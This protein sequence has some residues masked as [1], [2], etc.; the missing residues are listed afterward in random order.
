MCLIVAK[1]IGAA[2]PL[3]NHLRNGFMKNT[4]GSGV[5]FWKKDS[6]IIHIKKDFKTFPEF[7]Q[8]FTENVTVDD[9]CIVHFRLGTH[10]LSDIGNRH[11][12]P[13]TNDPE[14]LRTP[15]LDC[16]LATAHNGVLTQY[17]RADDKK[18]SDTQR[19]IIE[20][21]SDPLVKDNLRQTVI[22][23][24]IIEFLDNDKLS[25]LFPNGEILLFG[26]FTEDEGCHFSNTGYNYA[27]ICN[28]YNN[29]YQSAARGANDVNWNRFSHW[30]ERLIAGAEDAQKS[31]I[32]FQPAQKSNEA[33]AKKQD[34][35]SYNSILGKCDSC[36]EEKVLRSYELPNKEEMFLFCKKCRKQA[37]K[38]LLPAHLKDPKTFTKGEASLTEVKCSSCREFYPAEDLVLEC[39]EFL[40][41]KKCHEVFTSKHIK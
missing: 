30:D 32:G 13:V 16:L 38:G 24:L 11:P 14:L 3:E 8:Y 36:L 6:S 17:N 23:K 15:E 22:K 34:N 7:Y 1:P 4:D 9:A 28:H 35:Q 2:L 39:N 19:F 33:S 31:L 10:G 5:A 12:F 41:C 21:L 18:L 26:D 20:I 27:P 25:V 40:V 37:N 29:N